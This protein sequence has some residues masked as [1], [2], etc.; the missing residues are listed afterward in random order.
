MFSS[1]DD[2]DDDDAYDDDADDD[3]ADDQYGVKC[4]CQS[5]RVAKVPWDRNLLR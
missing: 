4:K 3:D 5:V 2:D 1:N